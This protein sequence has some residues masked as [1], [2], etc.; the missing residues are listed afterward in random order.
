M[1]MNLNNLKVF[2]NVADSGGVTRTAKAL[3]ISQPAVSKAIQTIEK[4]LG[5]S[6]FLRDKK[7]GVKLTDAGEHILPYARQMLLMEE[8]IYQTAYLSKNML[9]G[10]LKIASLPPGID[11]ILVKALAAFSKKYPNVN[12]EILEGSTNEVNRMV[13]DHEAEFGISMAPSDGFQKETLIKDH[14]VAFSRDKPDEDKVRLLQSKKQFL[15]C[16]A[17][18]ETIQPILDTNSLFASKNFRIVGPSTVRLMAREGLGIGIQSALMIEP[19]KKDFYIYPLEPEIC[20]DIV[21]IANDFSDLSP[22]A[23]AFVD[24]IH[25]SMKH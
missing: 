2:V 17:V 7:T 25:E 15:L 6:L 23:T 16:R 24:V 21:L 9:E 8:K 19:Y 22:A 5:V 13:I 12:V 1:A 4:D 20:T 14:I 18:M 11:W 10:T 3:F